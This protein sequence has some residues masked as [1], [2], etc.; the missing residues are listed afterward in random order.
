MAENRINTNGGKGK[1]R[2]ALVTVDK[3]HPDSLPLSLRHTY[4][5]APLEDAR[6]LLVLLKEICWAGYRSDF[7][8]TGWPGMRLVLNLIQD[9]VDIANGDYHFPLSGVSDDPTMVEREEE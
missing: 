6:A 4:E 1:E 8:F 9:K 5:R 2:T 3:V 7:Q